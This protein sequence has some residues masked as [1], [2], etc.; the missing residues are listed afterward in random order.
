M[1]ERTKPIKFS[2]SNALAAAC[3]IDLSLN[4][5]LGACFGLGKLTWYV[6]LWPR[7]IAVCFIGW[8]RKKS[9]LRAVALA[10]KHQRPFYLL[11]DGL[12]RSFNTAVAGEPSLSWVWDDRGIF[13]DARTLSRL[14]SL[15]GSSNLTTAQRETAERVL[16]SI[17]A[18]GLSKYNHGLPVPAGYFP[19]IS[20]RRVLL[21]D[22]TRGDA[23]IVFGNASAQSFEAMLACALNE[24]PD[25]EHWVK[26]HPDVLANKRQ[27]C[28][29][30]ANHP[31]IRIITDDFHPHDL[32]SHFDRVFVVTSQM[33]FDALLLHKPVTCFGQPFYAGWGLTDDKNAPQRRGEQRDVLDLV[34]AVYL[35]YACY[36]H[37]IH[38]T[39][40]DFF[41][42]AQYITRQ[43]QATRFWIDPLGM[44]IHKETNE[45]SMTNTIKKPRILCFGFR[46]WKRAQVRPFF[47][48]QVRLVFCD[49]LDDAIAKGIEATDQFAVWSSKADSALLDYAREQDIP[50]VQVEDGFLRSV[51]LGSDFVAPLSLVFDRTGIYSNPNHPSDLENMLQQH[52]FSEEECD[53]AARLVERI[54]ANRITKYN[55]DNDTPIIIKPAG[56]SVILIPGQVADDASIRM[57]AVHVRTNEELILNVRQTN[58]DAFIIYKPHPDV[59]SG[60]R[61]GI[62]SE[63]VLRKHCDLVAVDQSVL[64]CLDVADEVHT[65]TSLTGFDALIRGIKVVTYGM[66]FYA[67]WGLTHD[68]NSCPRRT[69][70]LTLNQLVAGTLLRYPRYCLPQHKG[71]VH[72]DDVLSELIHQKAKLKTVRV[73]G[74]R[75]S[76]RKWSGFF[77]SAYHSLSREN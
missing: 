28:I 21:V 23:S 30:L 10:Q 36:V 64:S 60:N 48:D 26:I 66:P 16:A 7:F 51:G 69:R 13:Y 71:F 45:Q 18:N 65:I 3:S 27:G 56:R 9:G 29:N 55:V 38:A 67:G 2:N 8:G 5:P 57:G 77:R 4:K 14:E 76:M 39:A 17:Q 34:H 43:K 44:N 32:I 49:S 68:H 74:I 54:V 73:R 37:P 75:R 63:S 20:T 15:I 31:H 24:E 33:G 35:E 58:P 53:E 19:N 62:V 59:A 25:A 47:G 52:E 46:F 72:A 12:L 1:K 41:T 70:S 6:F 11:E 22:Q 40:S 42:V 50:L 61:Q